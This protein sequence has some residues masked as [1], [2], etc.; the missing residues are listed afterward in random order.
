MIDKELVHKVTLSSNKEVILRD[1][2]I[3][4]QEMAMQNVAK[5]AG[6]SA[7]LMGGLLQ[8]ELLR[9]LIVQIDGKP[10]RGIELENLDNLFSYQEYMQLLMVMK[11]LMGTEDNDE[12]GKFQLEVVNY[13]G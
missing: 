4:H 2:K 5:K 1:F 12:L 11:K 7:L 13:G 6:D 9:L 3:K 10:V 8:S